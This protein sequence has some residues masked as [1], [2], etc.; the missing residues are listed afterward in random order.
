MDVFQHISTALISPIFYPFL[1]GQRIDIIYLA[2]AGLIG[3]Y[4]Y[5]L[6]KRQ[7]DPKTPDSAKPKGLRAFL[8]P[9]KIYW[10]SSAK[11]DYVY[12]FVSKFI[13]VLLF[14]PV[15]LSAAFISEWVGSKLL[16]TFGPGTVHDA[17]GFWG[18][19]VL[20]TFL[21]IIV[22]DFGI[23]FSHLLFHKVPLLWEFHKVHH[24]AEVLTPITVYR[25]HPVDDFLTMSFVAFLTG[26]FDGLCA[27]FVPLNAHLVIVQGVNLFLFL[28]YFLGY[29]LR[30]S[31]LWLYYGSFWGKIFISPAQHQ[32]HHSRADEHCD[33]NLGFIFAFWDLWAGTLYLPKRKE[34]LK[35]GL[36][37]NESKEY[38]TP[39]TLLIL[40]FKK[41]CR[42][43]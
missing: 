37:G 23:F 11:I 15:I 20:Y 13:F 28:F 35:L 26:I 8:L 39:L 19:D 17:A 30:H 31:H 33:K 7:T 34:D 27:Y 32:I 16:A 40:P 5:V 38:N 22:V 1:P 12:L 14:A 41:V 29:N 18:W 43:R 25:M 6:W 24:S 36:R 4:L 21:I 3:C 2:S 9:G 42:L 10:H